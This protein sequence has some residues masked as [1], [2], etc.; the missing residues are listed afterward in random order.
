V[1]NGCAGTTRDQRHSI[2]DQ[3]RA[4]SAVSDGVRKLARPPV[5][6][7]AAAAAAAAAAA[8]TRPLSAASS[9]SAGDWERPRTRRI[10]HA[11]VIAPSAANR[12][13]PLAE[14]VV[15][16]PLTEV[17][18]SDEPLVAALAIE[19]LGACVN[20]VGM[21]CSMGFKLFFLRLAET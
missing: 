11:P 3:L 17:A 4:L 15:F 12:L 18:L 14:A 8:P 19:T 6:Y 20:G 5:G 10:T 21:L 7:S 2:G 16:F 13:A 1:S 9:V